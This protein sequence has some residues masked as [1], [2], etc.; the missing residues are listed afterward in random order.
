MAGEQI[1]PPDGEITNYI[2]GLWRHLPLPDGEPEPAPEY[3]LD[4]FS[5]PGSS[6]V[7]ARVRGKKHKHDGTNCD[8]W[9]EAASA[10]QITCIAVSDGAGS[11]KFS[12]IGAREACRAAVSSLAELLERDFS[13]RPE[14]W[15]H[16]LLPAADSRCTAAWGVLAEIVQKSVMRA[17]AAVEAAWG[18]RTGKPAYESL[19][20]RELRLEDFSA[21]LLAVV[22]VPTGGGE[23]L[24]AACQTGDGVIAL[25]DTKTNPSPTV[26]L[27]GEADSGDFSGETEFLT[28]PRMRRLE[29]LQRRTRITRCA[30]DTVFVMTDG[31]SD[32][33]F[34]PGEG[35]P[36]LYQDLRAAGVLGEA[37]ADAG[38]RLRQWLDS[39]AVRGSFDDRTLVIARL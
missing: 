2:A 19:L 16:A 36:A 18:A 10:G 25:L 4:T 26:R 5:F 11:R 22:L 7:A 37:A 24:A 12:R 33:Y 15:E 13:G 38:Q 1:R 30:V 32:D 3:A 39:Y 29:L 20:G 14:I 6:V 9:Y 31:V 27:L 34:P 35:M 21:T 23:C 8:D 17:A 28:S